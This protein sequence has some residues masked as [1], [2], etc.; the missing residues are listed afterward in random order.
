MEKQCKKCGEKISKDSKF[1]QNCGSKTTEVFEDKFKK[2]LFL[3]KIKIA[4]TQAILLSVLGGVLVGLGITFNKTLSETNLAIGIG[5]GIGFFIA[6]IGLYEIATY[7]ENKF[8]DGNEE[9]IP[10]WILWIIK[11]R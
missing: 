6:G 3:G 10:K 5:A 1:C 2:N 4:R 8:L 9:K 7:S 11:R